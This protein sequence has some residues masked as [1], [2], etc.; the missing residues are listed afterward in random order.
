MAIWHGDRGRKVTGGRIRPHVKKKRKR[1]L[2][3][4]FVKTR[5]SEKEKRKV[6]K[7]KGGGIKIK[8]TEA[9][10][11]NVFIPSKKQTKKV[12]ILDV[13]E[14]PA[15]PQLVRSKIITKGAIVQTELGKAKITSRP[16]QDGVLNAVLI[17]KL[18]K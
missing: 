7:T 10:F 8:L 16:G 3:R 11:V 6:V 17:E 13:L 1:E 4:E 2:G 9:S 5:F 18:K 14:N 12:K 15:N